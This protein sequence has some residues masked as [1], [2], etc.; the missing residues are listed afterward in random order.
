MRSMAASS[1]RALGPYTASDPS[2]RWSPAN[3]G[4]AMATAHL[5]AQGH[6]RIA[7]IGDYE[8]ITTAEHRYEGFV[9]AM[10]EA[11]LT[12]DP[13]LVHREAHSDASATA[14]VHELM[15]L[16]EPPTAI[17]GAQNLI[18]MGVVRALRDLGMQHRIALVGFD[19]FSM[20][21]AL[22]PAVTVVAQDPLAIGRLAAELAFARI[23]DPD[24]PTARHVVPSILITRGSGE[25]RPAR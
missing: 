20:A 9:A 22:E 1:T 25:I 12:I 5:I 8:R 17:F 18:T 21:D 7:F 6:S 16:P 2:T 15:A 23:D 3:T 10:A 11:G 24:L 14:I 13:V 4:A 19:D